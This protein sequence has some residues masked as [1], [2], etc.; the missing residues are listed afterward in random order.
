MKGREE[1]DQTSLRGVCVWEGELGG[2]M[3]MR[4]KRGRRDLE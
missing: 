4:E 2:R 3:W 1:V